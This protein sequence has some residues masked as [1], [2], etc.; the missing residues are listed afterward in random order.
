MPNNKL[1]PWL[2]C[3]FDVIPF[4]AGLKFAPAILL[5][6]WE[7][8]LRDINA[9][10]DQDNTIGPAPDLDDFNDKITDGIL[11]PLLVE[12]EA[13][14]DVE[15][16]GSRVGVAPTGASLSSLV[17]EII[18]LNRKQAIV[19]QRI[20]SEA[21]SW[22]CFPYDWSQRQQTLLYV[23]GEGGV[24]KSQII[25]EIVAGMD[26]LR[27]KYELI[28][29]A[30]TGAV[31]DLIWVKGL[32]VRRL[33]SRKIIMVNDEVS[34]TDR[35][36]LNTINSHCKSARSLDRT[37]PDLFSGLPIVILMGDFYQF[38]PVRSQPLWKPPQNDVDTD[39][40]L[41]WHRFSQVIIPDERMR[42]TEDVPYQLLLRR[43]RTGSLTSNDVLMLNG[44]AITS[45]A[46]SHP[47]DTTAI[48]TLNSLQT[49][50]QSPP[51]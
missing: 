12:P 2:H 22:A 30:P 4:A 27:C 9:Q 45:L 33:W 34:M 46:N 28:F 5:Q 13:I 50:H 48:V 17:S 32:R 20:I 23:G 3:L 26:L 21:L 43:A 8:C 18:P 47:Q 51:N 19:V 49:C 31:A 39:G 7:A 6:S 11:L 16:R 40:R 37:S 44:R 15:E 35:S 29:M 1:L 25:K 24:G 14:P 42:Q 36:T 38:P 41:I 10:A